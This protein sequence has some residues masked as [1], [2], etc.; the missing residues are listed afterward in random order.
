MMKRS[1]RTDAA[2]IYGRC[3]KARAIGRCIESITSGGPSD[4]NKFEFPDSEDSTYRVLRARCADVNDPSWNV[5]GVSLPTGV[6]PVSKLCDDVVV[7]CDMMLQ[8]PSNSRDIND[9]SAELLR[10]IRTLSVACAQARRF[11]AQDRDESALQMTVD[12]TEA[13]VHRIMLHD[14]NVLLPPCVWTD[15][16]LFE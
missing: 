10:D 13:V 11:Y 2:R 1:D 16:I 15:A 9:L 14:V 3:F 12:G 8:I 4:A 6:K 5:L 7:V